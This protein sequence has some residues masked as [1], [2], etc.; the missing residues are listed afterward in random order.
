MRDPFDND[1]VEPETGSRQE[2]G[3]AELALRKIEAARDRGASVVTRLADELV[4]AMPYD[5]PDPARSTAIAGADS[6]SA[7]R[8]VRRDVE[9]ALDGVLTTMHE[10]MNTVENL[11]A[12]NPRTRNGIESL[13]VDCWM[14]T[15]TRTTIW[16]HN[17]TFSRS[18]PLELRLTDVTDL[19]GKGFD[20]AAAFDPR[21][22]PA[23]DPG[24]SVNSILSITPRP[25]ARRGDYHGLIMVDGA[26]EL[27]PLHIRL[28]VLGQTHER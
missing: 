6:A 20:G 2:A 27:E 8:R 5:G 21:V 3:A 12:G 25:S 17:V 1:E 7:I 26:V 14:G 15:E 4:R 13:E 10:A 24:Q 19:T 28:S 22:L 18:D 11:V 23:L 9:L 16:I